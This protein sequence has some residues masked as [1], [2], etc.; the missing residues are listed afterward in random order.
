MASDVQN[1]Q[2]VSANSLGSLSKVNVE[3][4]GL[5]AQAT[6]S[7]SLSVNLPSGRRRPAVA[8]VGQLPSTR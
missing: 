3:S 8:T 5:T 4:A 2:T 6:N 1:G 7:G